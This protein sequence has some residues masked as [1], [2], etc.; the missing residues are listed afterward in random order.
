MAVTESSRGAETRVVGY[1][2]AGVALDLHR[3]R[4][5]VDGADVATTPLLLQLLQILCASQGRLLARQ[6]LFDALWPGGQTV[7]E[8]ALSQ[9]IW[10]LRSL[11]GA[12]GALIVTVRRGGVRLDAT[13]SIDCTG[14][15]AAP[16]LHT[17]PGT[18]PSPVEPDSAP[19]SGL[20]AD[21]GGQSREPGPD[22]SLSESMAA[23]ALPRTRR[24]RFFAG[25]LAAAVLAAGLA[26]WL[27]HDP[28]V[29]D[30]Y[31]LRSSDLQ[32]G[33][34]DTPHIAAA[35]FAAEE[36]GDRER[37][38]AL[39]RS[40]HESDPST[41]VP[42][43]MLAWWR[44]HAAPEEAAAWGRAARARLNAETPPFLRLFVD[45]FVVRSGS[46]S[47]RGP[48]NAALELRPSAWRMQY[49]RAHVL[50]AD[51]DFAGALRSLQQVPTRVPEAGL[52]A[53]V[54]AD[55]VSLG[56]TDAAAIARE[57]PAMAGNPVLRPYLQGREAYSAGRLADAIAALDESA[58]RAQESGDYQRQLIAGELAG[59]AAFELGSA[60]T[61]P[62]LSALRR[63]CQDRGR[64]DCAATAL[65][66]QSVME[67]RR[68]EAARASALLADAWN[69]TPHPWMRPALLFIAL[70]N[71]LA[72]PGD[73][74]AVA[75]DISDD[76]AFA[77]GAELLR[78]WQAL[79]RGQPAQARRELDLAFERGVRQTYSAEDAILLAARLGTPA[80]P[81]RVDPPFPN[82]LRLSACLQL[83]DYRK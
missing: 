66:L 34:R 12:H 44:S 45:Y 16:V 65:G 43:A 70:E 18:G 28:L 73:V 20:H 49:T 78:G 74:E 21:A 75:E 38:I 57:H 83:R 26:A 14:R 63:L 69:L 11:L 24:H 36:A 13:V 47:Y 32:A 6:E 39:M 71:Q 19:S 60:D 52:L 22:T 61:L 72:T 9:L 53:D 29:F 1:R 5:L 58:R 17:S 2:F 27:L 55:R 23:A 51:R 8:A 82:P 40:L 7:S 46:E 4:L 25:L 33:R 77:G 42:A 3:G 31:A 80:A 56:D 48:L 30:G 35:A 62:R 37:A 59:M 50:L 81:C 76:P 68:G 10:R 64:L 67:A 15:V 41:P 79:A 54:L